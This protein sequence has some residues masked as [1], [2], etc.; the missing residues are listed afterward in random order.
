MTYFTG[1]EASYAPTQQCIDTNYPPSVHMH[2]GRGISSSSETTRN[3]GFCPAY[4]ASEHDCEMLL[5]LLEPSSRTSELSN[6]SSFARSN[7]AIPLDIDQS[8]G[9]KV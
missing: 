6:K 8:F 3:A 7:Q 2:L 4:Q 5:L 9:Q 1:F